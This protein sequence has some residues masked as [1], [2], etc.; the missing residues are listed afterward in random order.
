[1]RAAQQARSK[2]TVEAI[3]R[4][5]ARILASKGWAAF[6]TNAVATR[7][8]VSIGSLYEYFPNKQV[9]VDA[10]LDRHLS[11]A[12]QIVAQQRATAAAL[13]DPQAIVATLVNGFIALHADDPKLHRVLAS[14]VPLSP[15]IRKRVAALSEGVVAAT[16]A[17]LHGHVRDPQLAARLLVDTADALTH[18]WIVEPHGSPVRAELLGRELIAMLTGYLAVA[19]VRGS[20]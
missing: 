2:A 14:E 13:T 12:E 4:A 15:A 6:N 11:Q 20:C 16:A 1:M 5:A 10:L 3:L 8:G 7:A 9:I 17:A 19:G 18:R